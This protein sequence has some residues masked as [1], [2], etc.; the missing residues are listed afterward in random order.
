MEFENDSVDS[1]NDAEDYTDS[2]DIAGDFEGLEDSYSDALSDFEPDTDTDEVS[3]FGLDAAA[4]ALSDFESDADNNEMSDFELDAAAEALSD[5]G[6]DTDTDEQSDFELD[7]AAEALS[8]FELD[9]DS[10]ELSELE[11]GADTKDLACIDPATSVEELSDLEA[12]K[13]EAALADFDKDLELTRDPTLMPEQLSL[14]EEMER[15]GEMDI[16]P[17]ELG[18]GITVR[19]DGGQMGERIDVNM[20]CNPNASYDKESFEAQRQ[21]Q[22]DGFS[23]LTYSDFLKNRDA[24]NAQGRSREGTKMQEQ[25][26]DS[27]YETQIFDLM[28][29]NPDLTRNEAENTVSVELKDGAALHNPDQVAGGFPTEIHGYGSSAVN[30]ALGSLWGHGRADALYDQIKEASQNMTK[31]ELET[32]YLNVHLNDHPKP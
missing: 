18:E 29:H 14:I 25:Y 32:T 11:L 15:S 20:P 22:E 13:I 5:F 26:K 8:D 9:T 12:E 28:E 31:E 30:S 6:P 23:R 17:S 27:L 4:E 16:L 24:Y 2:E 1:V 7:A 3:D 10:E 19:F 21:N